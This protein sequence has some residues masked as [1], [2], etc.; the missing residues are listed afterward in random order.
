MEKQ[1]GFSLIELLIVVAIILII[2]AIAVPNLLKS[3]MAA[4]E[5][6]AAA[7]V[8]TIGTANVTYSSTYNVGYAPSLA[9]LGPTIAGS[10]GTASSDCADLVDSVIAGTVT[11]P[12]TPTPTK[13]GYTF[14][15]SPDPAHTTPSTTSPNPTF[16][17]T[18]NP[19]SKNNTGV[20]VFCLDQTNVVYK[21]P[22]PA[23]TGTIAPTAPGV[24]CAGV[25]APM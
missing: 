17:V 7:S 19:V 11:T 23:G 8:R 1:K 13:S 16:T 9:K 14:T 15:Y 20:S 24:S 2:A 18:A 10:C 4:N 5:S 3:K 12:P 22:S 25:G 6:S 21:D